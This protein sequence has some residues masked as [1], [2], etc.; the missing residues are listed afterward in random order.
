VSRIPIRLRLTLVFAVVM[1]AVLATVGLVL[2]VRFG[3]ALDERIA[4]SLDAR[5]T[6]LR[7][8]SDPT[9]VVV[10]GDEGVGQLLAADGAVAAGS[11]TATR[12]TSLL[13]AEQIARARSGAF[14]LD[15]G[16]YRLRAT[17]AGD[18]VLV[19]GEPLDDRDEA[20]NGLL[21]QLLVVLPVALLFSSIIGYLVAGGALRPVEAMRRRAAAIAADTPDRRLPLPAARDEV[22][23]LGETLNEMLARLDAGLERERRFVADASH[24]LRTPLAILKAELEVALRQPRSADELHAS[25]RSAADE[26]DRLVRLAEDLLLVARSDQSALRIRATRVSGDE[27]LVG[28][29]ARFETRAAAAGRTVAVED[30]AGLE[31]DVDRAHV[32]RALGNLVE[33]ALLYGRGPVRLRASGLGSVVE[34]HVSDEGDGF[35]PRFLRVAFERFTRADEARASKG[36]GL[37]LAIVD[38]VARAHGGTATAENL[39]GGGADVW[40]ALPTRLNAGHAPRTDRRDVG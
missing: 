17:P 4:D 38:A 9:A 2:Y 28:V 30:A 26:T 33:N 34:L 11:S 19:V 18:Q 40:I 13:T 10:A 22:Y 36:T 7:Q 1:A 20:L 14:T 5:T 21:A 16:G 8:T 25:I 39:E 29:A 37:G 32:E 12:S 24:E 6:A 35:D 31:L 15:S 3:H 23:R 27:L